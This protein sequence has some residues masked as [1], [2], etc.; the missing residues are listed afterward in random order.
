MG[1]KRTYMKQY[2]YTAKSDYHEDMELSVAA[3]NKLH[4]N[5]RVLIIYKEAC[6]EC[7]VIHSNDAQID[8]YW[9]EEQFME[10]RKIWIAEN[11]FNKYKSIVLLYA[12]AEDCCVKTFKDAL[13]NESDVKF[14]E[15]VLIPTKDFI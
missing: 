12:P 7:D 9:V 10:L 11:P 5:Q 4:A 15:Y 1:W 6:E 8:L 3:E 14:K 13:G 2:Y